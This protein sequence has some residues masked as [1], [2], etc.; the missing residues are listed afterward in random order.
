MS[1][2]ESTSSI[3]A[4]RGYTP[5]M[6]SQHAKWKQI[7]DRLERRPNPIVRAIAKPRLVAVRPY[8]PPPRSFQTLEPLDEAETVE[9]LLDYWSPENELRP[10]ATPKIELI[11]SVVADAFGVTVNDIIS[12][13]RTANVVL[14]RMIA[15]YL[16]KILRPDSLPTIGRR[17]GDR[18]HTT[19]LYSVRQMTWRV[20]NDTTFAARVQGLKAMIEARA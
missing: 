5:E 9:I 16:A 3:L 11:Q 13:R 10:H 6:L 1:L 12:Q 8:E 18:D 17:F 7:H 15:V 4:Q 14:P 20:E 2:H 19:V